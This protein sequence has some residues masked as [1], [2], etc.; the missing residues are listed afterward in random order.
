MSNSDASKFNNCLSIVR[1]V[2]PSGEQSRNKLTKPDRS[3]TRWLLTNSDTVNRLH[4]KARPNPELEN[5]ARCS[6][7]AVLIRVSIIGGVI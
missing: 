6:H 3:K 1:D 4:Q 2:S 7:L 5:Q